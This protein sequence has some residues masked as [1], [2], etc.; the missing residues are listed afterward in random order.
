[1]RVSQLAGP[2]LWSRLIFLNRYWIDCD[3]LWQLIA[4]SQTSHWPLISCLRVTWFFATA[5]LLKEI[6]S[7]LESIHSYRRN[8]RDHRS[9]PILSS[10]R[11]QDT[12]WTHFSQDTYLSHILT[13]KMAF[14]RHTNKVK[15]NFVQDLCLSQQL[16]ASCLASHAHKRTFKWSYRWNHELKVN[17]HQRNV[18]R[19]KIYLLES[20]HMKL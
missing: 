19:R 14:C 10:N 18:M 16:S 3:G 17:L 6:R 9:W 5:P 4:E 11:H 12:Y 13:Q 7:S 8:E 20:I 15:I 1:M 2:P